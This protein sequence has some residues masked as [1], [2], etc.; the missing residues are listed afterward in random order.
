MKKLILIIAFIAISMSIFCQST[1]T[2]YAAQVG[3]WSK[4]KKDWIWSDVQEVNLIIT[5]NNSVIS[6]NNEMGSVFETIAVVEEKDSHVTWKALDEEYITCYL[7]MKYT[8]EFALL[9]ITYNDLCYRY[10]Y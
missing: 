7:T 10:Y 1:E 3:T 2:A 6:I 8:S 5:F 9:V 4:I